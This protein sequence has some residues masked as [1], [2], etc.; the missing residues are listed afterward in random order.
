MAES[1]NITPKQKRLKVQ[2][3]ID[4]NPNSKEFYLTK[5]EKAVGYDY[6]K[7]EFEI[8]NNLTDIAS[9]ALSCYD[10][11]G[12]F[13]ES[14]FDKLYN[15]NQVQLY[16]REFSQMSE[17]PTSKSSPESLKTPTVSYISPKDLKYPST[18]KSQQ[19]QDTLVSFTKPI[20]KYLDFN[21]LNN[22]YETKIRNMQTIFNSQSPELLT[23]NDIDSYYTDF[24]KYWEEEL[25]NLT[26]VA[27][28]ESCF[29]ALE[30]KSNLVF[31][32]LN[33]EK[34][35]YKWRDKSLMFGISGELSI[36]GLT[37]FA[38]NTLRSICLS[39][40]F[41]KIKEKKP[42]RKKPLNWQ[43]TNTFLEN[44]QNY[45]DNAFR[46]IDSKKG[47]GENRDNLNS[48]DCKNLTTLML[49]VMDEF[50][51]NYFALISL[52]KTSD[53]QYLIFL[54]DSY[55]LLER[56][57]LIKSSLDVSQAEGLNDL[58]QFNSFCLFNSYD[59][60]AVLN[61]PYCPV[62]ASGK[63][64]GYQEINYIYDD[65][66]LF[67]FFNIIKK[68]P[69]DIKILPD[70]DISKKLYVLFYENGFINKVFYENIDV[71]N[72]SEE[73]KLFTKIMN[74][75]DIGNITVYQHLVNL[76]SK[77][78]NG[79]DVLK[80][81]YESVSKLFLNYNV[82]RGALNFKELTSNSRDIRAHDYANS[83]IRCFGISVYIKKKINDF[84]TKLNIQ[85]NDSLNEL[86]K[87]EEIKN[88]LNELPPQQ[89]AKLADFILIDES[90][91]GQYKFRTMM[92]PQTNQTPIEKNQSKYDS[93]LLG[94]SYDPLEGF[95]QEIKEIYILMCGQTAAEFESS[96]EID[97]LKRVLV[98]EQFKQNTMVESRVYLNNGPLFRK[99]AKYYDFNESEAKTLPTSLQNYNF[100]ENT[101]G[102]VDLCLKRGG[103]NRIING[104][105]V[106]TTITEADAAHASLGF[107]TERVHI[108]KNGELFYNGIK[109]ATVFSGDFKDKYE[110]QDK[111][112]TIIA[113]FK[114]LYGLNKFNITAN[115]AIPTI[116][117]LISDEVQNTINSY[118]EQI[119]NINYDLGINIETNYNNLIDGIEEFLNSKLQK[120]GLAKNVYDKCSQLIRTFIQNVN[121]ELDNYIRQ[122]PGQTCNVN[123]LIDKI[124]KELYFI[125]WMDNEKYFTYIKKS[126]P[127]RSQ[128]EK[129]K[130]GGG[131]DEEC[132]IEN[133][134]TEATVNLF[135]GKY[136][137]YIDVVNGKFVFK[138]IHTEEELKNIENRLGLQRI[139]K[140]TNVPFTTPEKMNKRPFFTS[141]R[142]VEELNLTPSEKRQQDQQEGGKTK[143]RRR[144]TVKRKTMR[145]INKNKK[146]YKLVRKVNKNK[147][148]I[149]KCIRKKYCI[150]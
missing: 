38:M 52:K 140:E 24:Q 105:L 133:N 70:N 60:S 79:L 19:S 28:P 40:T 85:I 106:E 35:C 95:I 10:E 67:E 27:N 120:A 64:P 29:T 113:S 18:Q 73:S 42:D 13:N 93:F 39:N 7:E 121:T 22:E 76:S 145:K 47:E 127:T 15:Q 87:E 138:E 65:I 12:N 82:S 21:E 126:E 32:V 108:H 53:E 142:S 6:V 4:F 144:M 62:L 94:E 118:I 51:R 149:T 99:D 100:P 141:P 111:M 139:I 72:T 116:N 117:Y 104:I 17:S 16:N 50:K 66:A 1:E 123:T 57:I 71:A 63:F 77:K 80:T 43:I 96:Q 122:N 55:L 92:D 14:L 129:V 103:L 30:I 41:N 109:L 75:T 59:Y 33:A 46:N 20:G 86:E 23:K 78:S 89:K 11:N 101:I 44:F 36:A 97:G 81:R 125:L 2:Q 137:N 69:D 150:K 9:L 48:S 143:K 84:L 8:N 26:P 115:N 135:S 74:N 130:K 134:P 98:F 114:L 3:D 25:E 61:T 102:I 90:I 110:K 146:S 119:K 49:N 128:R 124:G 37:I 34:M 83:P 54:E 91:E 131:K 132:L 136:G 68:P 58:V 5:S 148:K 45:F 147:S 31:D 107:Y 56:L 88:I 112:E